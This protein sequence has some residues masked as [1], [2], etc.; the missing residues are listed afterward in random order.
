LT[1]R[2]VRPKATCADLASLFG[3]QGLPGRRPGLGQIE[4]NAIRK[5]HVNSDCAINTEAH[6]FLDARFGEMNKNNKLGRVFAIA[7]MMEWTRRAEKQ[8]VIS[9]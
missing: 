5:W 7:P 9:T 2:T 4:S 6:R 3:E 1:S 8:S